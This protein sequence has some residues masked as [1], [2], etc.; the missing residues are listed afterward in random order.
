MDKLENI[1]SC[2]F[3]LFLTIISSLSQGQGLNIHSGASLVNTG[4]I[5]LT[6]NWISDGSFSD[7]SGTV[8]FSG[9][10]QSIGG[11]IPSAFNN[12]T[13]SSGSNTSVITGGQ[14]LSRIL[15]SNG[16]LNSNGNL[17]LIST[18]ALTALIDGSGTGQVTGNVNMQRYLSDGGYK[19]FSSPFS[20]ATVN[21]FNE[22]V[23]LGASFPT[24]YS[25]NENDNNSSGWINYTN[26]AGPLN[27]LEGYAVNFGILS[28]V[29]TVSIS[30][31]VN[32]G[33]LSRNISNHN[34]EFTKGFNLAGNPYPSPID[35]DA[36]A[37]WTKNNID[38][39]LYYFRS[40]GDQYS[41]TYSTYV[42]GISSDGQASNIIPSM[43]GFFIHVSNDVTYPVAGTLALDNR[44]RITD[45]SHSF[46]K[47]DGAGSFPILKLTA[48]FTDNPSSDD[49]SVIYFHE[50]GT[51]D[52][53]NRLDALKL[54]NTD[55]Q[56]PNLYSVAADGKRLTINALPI[57]VD[58]LLVVP[59]GVKIERSGQVKFSLSEMDNLDPGISIY[60]HDEETATDRML[61]LLKGY[62]VNL[63]AGEYNDRFSVRFMLKE[64]N[65]PENWPGQDLLNAYVFQ[66]KLIADIYLLSGNSGT[67]T[68]SNLSGQTVFVKNISSLG[69][70]E[71][72]IFQKTGIYI[73]NFTTG[74]LRVSK[75]IFIHDR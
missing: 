6:G 54:F 59:L 67:L 69:Y 53:D 37:G 33:P 55:S 46:M 35:W 12:I 63:A 58:S 4:N 51:D 32:N 26:T 16:T 68:F 7:N 11:T 17:T 23:S 50:K 74:K 19:Y 56:T 3:A 21:Q 20:D 40:S 18:P 31:T 42:N 5:V 60:L 66:G 8:C 44:V 61:D 38:A 45:L 72:D 36:G 10:V 15:L 24:L 9:T 73:L 39:A 34:F 27:R 2:F 14:I 71:F 48:A 49:E 30:G 65:V 57:T 64:K 29:T 70:H 25:Y 75:K 47:S 28:T 22:E 13:I 52:F 1:R 43:Q 41:G 62:T